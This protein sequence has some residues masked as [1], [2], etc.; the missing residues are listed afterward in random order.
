MPD[1]V[2]AEGSEAKRFRATLRG[3]LEVPKSAVTAKLKRQ[4]RKRE[5][6]GR[7]KNSDSKPSP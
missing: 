7:Q 1:R 3:I 6:R 2:E 4:K 5:K